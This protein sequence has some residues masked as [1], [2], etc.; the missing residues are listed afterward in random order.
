MNKLGKDLEF[1]SRIKRDGT[2]VEPV[3]DDLVLSL[4]E[5]WFRVIPLSLNAGTFI[6]MGFN[7]YIVKLK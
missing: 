3:L 1:I 4:D 6:A 5:T 2:E 7:C